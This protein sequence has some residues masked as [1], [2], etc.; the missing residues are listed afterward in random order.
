M[1]RAQV[2]VLTGGAS[3]IGRHIATRLAELGHRLV[4]TDIDEPGL[5]RARAHFGWSDERVLT[6]KLDVRQPHQWEQ[7]LDEACRR[8]GRLDVLLNV[9]G[10]L[11]PGYVHETGPGEVDMHLDVNVKGV[12]FGTRAAARRM[13]ERGAGHIINVGSLAS[14]APVPGLCLY[15][16]SKFAVRGFSL[17]CAQELRPHGVAVS[18]VLPDAVRTPMLDLQKDYEEAALTFSGDGELLEPEDITALIVERVLPR[19]PLE[20]T[21]PRGRGA[22]ARAVNTLPE[23]ALWVGPALAERG[24]ARQRDYEKGDPKP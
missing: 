12:V 17:A 14:L 8:F 11:K 5:E 9:A 13:V 2:M 7:V 16:A 4:V 20:V 10:Y 6:R 23:L 21:I 1:S 22:L 3:G 19:R 15:S 24:R 18:V